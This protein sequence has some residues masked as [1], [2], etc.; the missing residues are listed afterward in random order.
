MAGHP[1]TSRS[2]LATSWGARVIL[3]SLEGVREFH[4]ITIFTDDG[5]SIDVG[6]DEEIARKLNLSTDITDY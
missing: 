4:R 6:W 3:R 5:K 1:P 2:I